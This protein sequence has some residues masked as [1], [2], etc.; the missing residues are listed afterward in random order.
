[1][2]IVSLGVFKPAPLPER[3]PS[4]N[5]QGATQEEV[6]YIERQLGISTYISASKNFKENE[7]SPQGK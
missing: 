1:M 2:L 5:Q 3:G 7:S 4:V 6:D